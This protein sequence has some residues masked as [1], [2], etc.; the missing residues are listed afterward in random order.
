[1]QISKSSGRRVFESYRWA[2]YIFEMVNVYIFHFWGCFRWIILHPPLLKVSDSVMVF[3]LKK[4]KKLWKSIG[5]IF[6]CAEVKHFHDLPFPHRSEV[7]L[8]LNDVNDKMS[9]IN[10]I[11]IKQILWLI[12][13]FVSLHSFLYVHYY[14][15]HLLCYW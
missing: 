1:M 8:R 13:F 4:G 7:K 15:Y 2:K 12:V 11:H 14:Y 9:D 3:G 5:E 6:C 10:I